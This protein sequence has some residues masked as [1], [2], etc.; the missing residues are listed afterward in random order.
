MRSMIAVAIALIATVSPANAQ[1]MS[2]DAVCKADQSGN[3]LL[4]SVEYESGYKVEAPW[5][6]MDSRKPR[7]GNA[8]VT[9]I[10]DHIIETD[11]ATR[12]RSLTPLPGA[13]EMTFTGESNAGLLREAAS[14][15]CHT[16]AKALAAR[17]A[18]T[19]GRVAQRSVVM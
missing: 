14:V 4:T 12:K 8:R 13:I 19:N 5:R 11:P 15:W 16:V 18:D 6:V 7:Q 10:L 3:I 17:K 2:D 9:A 1:A